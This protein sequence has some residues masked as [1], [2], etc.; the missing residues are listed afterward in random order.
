MVK[1]TDKELEE[2]IEK[3]VETKIKEYFN[4]KNF[5]K[6]AAKSSSLKIFGELVGY[7][8]LLVL[9]FVIFPRLPFVTSDFSLWLPIAFWTAT[10]GTLFKIFKHST[11]I[12]AAA[13][14]FEIGDITTSLYST[15]WLIQIFPLDFSKFGYVQANYYFRVLLYIV[16]FAMM[17]GILVNFIRIFM[18][19]K[20]EL[21]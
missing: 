16:L 14:L 10:L 9:L 21:K 3:I 15:Y 13:R 1:K 18:P 6:S 17:I 11:S 5:S 19:E 2:K 8:I 7:G 20:K 4:E 12:N